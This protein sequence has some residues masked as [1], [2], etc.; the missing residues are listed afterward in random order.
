MTDRVGK[1]IFAELPKHAADRGPEERACDLDP[2]KRDHQIHQPEGQQGKEKWEQPRADPFEGAG[3]DRDAATNGRLD[4][5]RDRKAG[6]EEERPEHQYRGVGGDL[7]YEP[8]P[9]RDVPDLVEVGLDIVEQED[10]SEDQKEK[11]DQPELARTVGELIEI[12]DDLVL[13]GRQELSEEELLRLL[14]DVLEGAEGRE[15]SES[16]RHQR[17]CGKQ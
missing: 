10:C 7:G 5:G 11:A 13:A 12:E 9:R 17:H 1:E 6:A 8:T 15:E 14:F 2:G 4:A 16:D 3:I